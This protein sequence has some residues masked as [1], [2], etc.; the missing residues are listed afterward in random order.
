MYNYRVKAK[1]SFNT[2]LRFFIFYCIT[3]K[4]EFNKSNFLN[5]DLENHYDII[6]IFCT[7][8][9]Q[10]DL[11]ESI[12]DI[13]CNLTVNQI[14]IEMEEYK[15][16]KVEYSDWFGEYFNQ[17]FIYRYPEE[18]YIKD[19]EAKECSYCKLTIEEIYRLAV[20]KKLWKKN[21]RGWKMEIDRKNPNLEYTANNCVPA[22][23]WC[24]NAKTDEFSA[25]EFRPI[26]ELIGETL[27]KRLS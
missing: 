12:K 25:K 10:L 20:N 13:D 9:Y 17:I 2:R 4:R 19:L 6:E 24:N 16:R 1:E 15:N 26:G 11:S 14:Y 23:Y 18:N 3:N 27:R 7:Q 8:Y 5:F 21:E 22:C